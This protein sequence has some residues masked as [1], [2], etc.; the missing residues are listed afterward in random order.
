[1]LNG[2]QALITGGAKRLGFASA[3]GLAIQGVDV[4]LHFNTSEQEVNESIEA[5]E[6][7]GV[8][9]SVIQGNLADPD[10]AETLFEKAE[11]Q[12]GPIDILVNNASIFPEDTMKESDFNSLQTNFAVNAYAPLAIAKSMAAKGR[13]GTVINMLDTRI[14]D[15]DAN[16]FSYHVSKRM[17]SDFTRTM[18][19]E[20]APEIRVN[21]IAPGLILP[22]EG[23]DNSYLEG[24]A[25]SN[26]L[27]D[28]GGEDDIVKALLFLIESTFVT[29]QIIFVDGGRHLKGHVYE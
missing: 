7:I 29:G 8:N 26:P 20:F 25:S 4:V 5:L 19:L 21:G 22:P 6:K 27:N 14:T 2:R 15:Y 24:L 17:L 18:S 13:R 16:H 10:V 11:T 3:K 23:K 9:V 28:V 1:M 12:S